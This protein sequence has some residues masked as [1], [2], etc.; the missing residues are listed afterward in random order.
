MSLRERLVCSTSCQY[1]RWQRL[2]WWKRVLWCCGV[3]GE[4]S[5][6]TTATARNTGTS[7]SGAWA[8]GQCG[9]TSTT[10][11]HWWD[12]ILGQQHLQRKAAKAA[13]EQ[14]QSR[15][16]WV[17]SEMEKMEAEQEA[18]ADESRRLPLTRAVAARGAAA[19]T[20]SKWTTPTDRRTSLRRG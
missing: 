3:M 5:L 8:T 17:L 20:G 4:Q 13:A 12:W 2:W 6:P 19:G 18:A 11:N 15:V 10:V 14:Q 1:H 7:W 9:G 16:G